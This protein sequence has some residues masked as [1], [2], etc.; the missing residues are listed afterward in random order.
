M[1]LLTP[2]DVARRVASLIGI[3]VLLALALTLL[4]QFYVH[5][6]QAGPYEGDEPVSVRLDAPARQD[7]KF[8]SRLS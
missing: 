1:G 8:A 4:C 6:D 7:V 3:L 5:H 2:L